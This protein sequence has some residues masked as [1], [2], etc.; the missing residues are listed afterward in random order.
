MADFLGY[1]RVSTDSQN[2]DRQIDA[3][4][5]AGVSRKHLYCEKMTGTKADR[6]ELNRMINDL[7]TGDTVII[8]DLTRISRSTKD[9]LETV[10]KIKNKGAYIKSLKDTWL[11]TTSNNP[12]NDFLLTVMSGLSQLERDLIS[13]RTKEGLVS[14]KARGRNGGRPSKQNEKAEMVMTLY[15]SG[16]KIADIVRNTELSRST[17]NRIVKNHSSKSEMTAV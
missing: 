4:I 2:L 16:M 17:V 5:A 6:P 3:L 12:Y 15:G 9:L 13:Q 1:A 8:A 10:D 14:A 11:D 7:E